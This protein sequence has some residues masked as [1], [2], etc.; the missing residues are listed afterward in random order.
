MKEN[1]TKRCTATRYTA[2]VNADVDRIASQYEPESYKHRSVW[3][4]PDRED[5]NSDAA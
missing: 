4:R 3:P 1:P 5:L 2:R